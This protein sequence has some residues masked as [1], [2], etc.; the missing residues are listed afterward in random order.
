MADFVAWL[1]RFPDSWVYVGLS[2]GAAVENIVPAV[3]ADTFVALG[4]F[5]AGAGGLQARWVA[6]G[7]WLANVVSALWVVQLSR[8]HGPS[9]FARG[10]GRYLVKPHQM[11]RLARF[12]DRWGLGAI[13]VSRFLPGFRA[14]VPVFAGATNQSVRRLAVP[15]AAASAIWYG[16]LVMLGVAAGRNLELLEARLGSIGTTLGI[17]AAIAALFV[18]G[19]WLKTRRVAHRGE[20]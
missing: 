7:T 1:N 2:V 20:S 5:L 12:Y 11:E 4:G 18:G 16:G 8:R 19:W 10:W 15:L 14:V 13:F 9:F 6:L 17:V 3:P